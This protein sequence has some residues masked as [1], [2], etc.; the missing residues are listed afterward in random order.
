MTLQN[1]TVD[2]WEEAD[3]EVRRRAEVV[4][5]AMHAVSR[6]QQPAERSWAARVDP[7]QAG[8]R[9]ASAAEQRNS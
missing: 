1:E 5:G 4:Q 8:D 3:H 6:L 9:N 2:H 7:R